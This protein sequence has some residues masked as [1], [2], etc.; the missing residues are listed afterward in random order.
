MSVDA[1]LV[2]ML[3]FG[4]LVIDLIG[5]VIKLIEIVI[6]QKDRK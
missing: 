1:A 4:V 6:K 3:T 2:I 5:L